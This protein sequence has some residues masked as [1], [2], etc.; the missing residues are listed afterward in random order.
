MMPAARRRVVLVVP[1][2][3]AWLVAGPLAGVQLGCMQKSRRAE[4]ESPPPLPSWTDGP[5]KGRILDFVSRV[6]DDKGPDFVPARDRIAVFDNDGTLWVEHPIPFQLMFAID[7][8]KKMLGDDPRLAAKQ[9]FKTLLGGE[10]PAINEQE[11]ATLLAETH[12]GMTPQAFRKL[13]QSWLSTARH[14][15]FGRIPTASTYQPQLE[16]LTFLRLNGFKIFIVTGGGVDFVR[17]FSDEAYGIPPE[18]VVGSSSK[19]EFEVE[20]GKGELTK[21]PEL[22]SLDDKAGKPMNINL[23]IGRRPILAFGNSDGDLQ[24]LQY[25]AGGGGP[26]LSLLV[27]HDDADREY[28]YDRLTRVGKL[29]RA[30]EEAARLDWVVVSMA[31]DWKTIFP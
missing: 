29:D 23:H 31:K 18:Q 27:R 28:A 19:T 10:A 8:A 24:M 22:E 17:A 3:L 11:I 9:P 12:S 4:A 21:L 26:S 2:W 1:L 13:A 20:G 25:T 15:R 16:L 7:R 30:L 6:T 5:A 14:P